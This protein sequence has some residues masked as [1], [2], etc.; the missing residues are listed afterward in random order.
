MA[1]KNGTRNHGTGKNGIGNNGTG[2]HGRFFTVE[3]NGRVR[4]TNLS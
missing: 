1:Q 3:T 4:V 2:D